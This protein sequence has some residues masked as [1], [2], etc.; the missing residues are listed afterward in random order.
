[1]RLSR[2]RGWFPVPNWATGFNLKQWVLLDADRL[3]V[4]GAL[5]TGVFMTFMLI[6]TFWTFEMQTLLTDT[7]TVQTILNT[8]LSGMILLVSIVVSI[9][10][11]VLSHDM[12]SVENQ[13]DRIQGAIEFRRSLSE[14]TEEGEDPS[15][16]S[17]FLKVMS[18]TIS[19]RA[20]V[21]TSD[22]DGVEEELVDDIDEYVTSVSNAAEQ[23]GAVEETS[24]AEFA[25]LWKGIEFDYGSH[26]ERSRTLGASGEASSDSFEDLIKAFEL[27]AIGKEYFKTL[28]YT[29]E[30]SQLSRTLLVVALPA[31][32]FNASA[33]IAINGEVLPDT[34]ILGIPSLQTFMAVAFTVS[35]A[36]YLVLTAYMLR[37]STVARLTASGGIFSLK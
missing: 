26:I 16:P 9:N 5:L 32:L 11:I 22:L 1:M 10:S 8:F 25:V 4:T 27:F 36:P 31:I 37:L 20:Q 29:K 18:R 7:S 28:Y 17:S 33:I 15:E 13:E 6:S 12:T 2:W 14:L 35:V 30:V 3:A 34:Q 19:A 23:L 21:L 24:G